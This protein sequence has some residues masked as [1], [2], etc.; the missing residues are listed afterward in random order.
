MGEERKVINIVEKCKFNDMQVKMMQGIRDYP[1]IRAIYAHGGVRSGKSLAVCKIAM[2]TAFNFPGSRTLI[3]RDT[4]VNL[5][6]TTL[7]TFFGID[8]KGNPVIMPGLYNAKDYNKT[9]GHLT[10]IN[11]SITCFWGMDS[12]EDVEKIKSTEWSLVMIEEAPGVDIEVIRFLMETRL[13]HAIGPHK[14]LLTSNT[15]TG[16]S[17]IYRLFYDDHNRAEEDELCQTCGGK[18]EMRTIASNTLQNEVNLPKTF[19]KR[20][21]RLKVTNPRYYDVYVMGKFMEFTKKIYPE[22]DVNIHVVDVPA[23]WVEPAGT[24]TVYGYDHGYAG[25]PSCLLVMKML[26]DGTFLAWEE[27]YMWDE[28]K[29][30]SPTVKTMAGIFKN[31]DFLYIHAADPSIRNKTQ[32]IEQDDGE[33]ELTSVQGLYQ[34]YGIS[35]EFA[36]N[37]VGAGI[38]KVKSLLLDDPEH[39]HPI[40]EGIDHAPYIMIARVGGKNQCPN[41]TRQFQKY[42]NKQNARGEVN[43]S[44]WV[45]VKDDDHALDPLR[46]IVNSPLFPHHPGERGPDM[47]TVR[48]VK[49]Q[50]RDKQ[51]RRESKEVVLSDAL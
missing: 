11:G 26:P 30:Q 45:P 13:S 17:D 40:L 48:W 10:W 43:P 28:E 50:M 9:E 44:K 3:A 18:C 4:R 2:Q 31:R 25:A 34:T 42:R 16:Y 47:G 32:Y 46:Y 27:L 35:M 39:H 24:Q 37:D 36:N 21:K 19:V 20:I 49:E 41:L 23:G 51:E 7:S 14:M 12:P 22:F 6:N 8:S 5:K 38:E 15:D 33:G 1:E 29:N